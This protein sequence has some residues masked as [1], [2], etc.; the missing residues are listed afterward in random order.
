[1]A[2]DVVKQNV[3]AASQFFECLLCFKADHGAVSLCSGIHFPHNG[4]KNF[5]ELWRRYI[6]ESLKAR[7]QSGDT[8]R[9]ATAPDPALIAATDRIALALA[10]ALDGEGENGN[11]VKFGL[12]SDWD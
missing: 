8:G 4:L 10:N 11:V 1:M 2:C 7:L 5:K 6:G 3:A 9:Y 12:P